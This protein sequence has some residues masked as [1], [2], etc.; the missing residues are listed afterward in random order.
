MTRSATPRSTDRHPRRT[1]STIVERLEREFAPDLDHATVVRC[2]EAAAEAVDLFGER[3][4]DMP[5]MIERIAREDL[6]VLAGGEESLAR[7][8]PMS[9]RKQP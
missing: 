9:R 4:Q 5:R 6:R 7:L 8:K 2:V 1:A 3:P